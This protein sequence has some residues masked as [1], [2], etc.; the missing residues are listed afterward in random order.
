M[1]GIL[2]KYFLYQ[3]QFWTAVWMVTLPGMGLVLWLLTCTIKYWKNQHYASKYCLLFF[4]Y[5]IVYFLNVNVLPDV[6]SSSKQHGH[7]QAMGT[8]VALC[9]SLFDSQSNHFWQLG[10]FRTSAVVGIPLPASPCKD[11]KK[12]MQIMLQQGPK[13]VHFPL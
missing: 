5:S 12:K 13:L 6:G 8:V 1:C 9:D 4:P 11:Y 10:L 7:G 3:S 2:Y